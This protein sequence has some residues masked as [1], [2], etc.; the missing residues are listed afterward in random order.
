MDSINSTRTF[1]YNR[2]NFTNT[3]PLGHSAIFFC[4]RG[5]IVKSDILL[6][7]LHYLDLFCLT[8]ISYNKKCKFFSQTIKGEIHLADIIVYTKI[9][10]TSL[11]GY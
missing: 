9:Q 8:K 7:H 4:K 6:N 5:N 1:R 2:N 11:Y 10:L 3:M